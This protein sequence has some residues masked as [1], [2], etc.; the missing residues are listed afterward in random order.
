MKLRFFGVKFEPKDIWI[1]VYWKKVFWLEN[2][3]DSFVAYSFYICIIPMF[4]LNIVI[5]TDKP[6]DG[7][8]EFF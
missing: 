4:P 3:D 6:T 7:T 8:E 2:L 1:G 5:Y